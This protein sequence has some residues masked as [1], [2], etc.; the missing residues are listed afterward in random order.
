MTRPQQVVAQ[1]RAER[2]RVTF[3]QQDGTKER[4]RLLSSAEV[5]ALTRLPVQ[6][7]WGV[8]RGAHVLDCTHGE[9]GWRP[10]RWTDDCSIVA[11]RA[12]G[13]ARRSIM[14]PAP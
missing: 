2:T 14:R 3:R 10:R 4:V 1:A 5:A 8:V 11:V 9:G 6:G 7:Q 12:S 13:M